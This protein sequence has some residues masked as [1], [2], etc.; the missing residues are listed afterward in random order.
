MAEV[1][2]GEEEAESNKEAGGER[3]GGGSS[4]RGMVDVLCVLMERLESLP[5]MAGL[6]LEDVEL[7]GILHL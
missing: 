4:I 1:A 2:Y 7:A 6:E 5:S 3:L